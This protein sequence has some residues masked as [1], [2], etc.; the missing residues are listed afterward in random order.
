MK[1]QNINEYSSAVADYLVDEY[2]DMT[3]ELEISD[4]DANN[5]GAIINYCYESGESIN[6]AAHHLIGFLRKKRT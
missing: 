6:N 3:K 4:T 5:A 1:F 2:G